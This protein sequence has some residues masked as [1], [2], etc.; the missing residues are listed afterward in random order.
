MGFKASDI[1]V[2]R[3]D[4]SKL[5]K[6]TTH[7]FGVEM[8]KRIVEETEIVR[9]ESSQFDME[10]INR[11]LASYPRYFS[12][13]IVE[14]EVI[15]EQYQKAERE[16]DSWYK[17]K[18][19]EAMNA[20][21]GKPTINVI[22]SKVVEMCAVEKRELHRKLNEQGMSEAEISSALEYEGL[23]GRKN[24]IMEFQSKANMAKGM[25]K[26]WAN[27]IHSLQ[28]LSKNIATEAELIKRQMGG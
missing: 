25:V 26:V 8:H 2:D 9:D 13:I 20:L 3:S 11:I 22:E 10:D 17:M 19:M 15:N 24:K 1:G 23:D 16:F 21:P 14:A 5:M 18:Y 6:L 4:F 7:K 12:W 28:S 27:A